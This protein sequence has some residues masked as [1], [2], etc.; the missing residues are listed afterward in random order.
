MRTVLMPLAEGFEELEAVTVIDLLRRAGVE[1][2]MAGLQPGRQALPVTA[3]RGVVVIPDTALDAVL[4]NDFDMIVL[5]GGLPGAHHL[6]DDE[7]VQ[8]I[9]KRHAAAG[10]YT[11]AICAAPVALAQAGLLA[12]KRAT[13]YPGCIEK[14]AIADFKHSTEAVVVDGKIVTSRGPGTAMDFALTLIELLCGRAQ[15]D[16]VETGLVRA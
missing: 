13:S 9:L 3:S 8:A 16:Q 2:V 7:R 12:G 4:G 10:A 5:P 6:R 15:R 1:V 14:L 11:A